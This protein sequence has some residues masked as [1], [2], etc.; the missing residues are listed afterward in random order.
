M[1]GDLAE[2]AR[3]FQALHEGPEP[4]VIPN[5]WDVGSARVLEGLGFAALATSSAG[6]AFTLGRCDG[7]VTR[8]EV[9]AHI[10]AVEQ[11]TSLPISAD[12]ENGFGDAPETAAETLRLAAEAGAV[13]GSI[14]DATGDPDAPLYE[15]E[16]AL[17]RV[18]A[19][20][21]TVRALEIPFVFTARAE[22]FLYGRP[23][24]DDTIR[25]LQAFEQAGAD[26]LYAPGL[27]D[28]GQIRELC[29]ALKKPV[30]VLM[31]LPGVTLS[32]ADLGGAGVTRI[33]VGS[34]F[35]RAAWGEVLRAARE[36]LDDGTFTF[37]DRT[38][39][40]ADLNPFM[41]GKPDENG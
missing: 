13:G 31:G 26:V 14:E 17:E 39:S 18:Q 6:F 38:A 19:C 9:I 22:N 2:K 5:P 30:N 21:E 23:D 36:T 24:L 27:K 32:V 12:L 8:D 28:I 3:R 29:A 34:N 20:V 10:R 4:F 33:S 41:T 37:G 25:R 40:F 11:A 16:Q 35:A 15:F 1:V 7:A